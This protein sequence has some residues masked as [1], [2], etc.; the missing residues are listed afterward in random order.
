MIVGGLSFTKWRGRNFVGFVEFPS[1]R[2]T[3]MKK[4]KF[5]SST[6]VICFCL[7][8]RVSVRVSVT[9]KKCHNFW[10]VGRTG[11]KFSGP[12]FLL[13]SNFWAGEPD[14]AALGVRP[15]PQI[16]RFLPNLFPPGVL[17][18]GGRVA[19]FRNPDNEANKMLGAEFWVLPYGRR[20]RGQKAGL[21]RGADQN[22][23]I[24][25]FFIKGT[26]LKSG[27]GHFL[28]YATFW[29][30]APRGVPGGVKIKSQNW[31]IPHKIKF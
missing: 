21:A 14:S 3:Y 4:K 26:P 5:C 18:Q 22:F 2:L 16:N 15:G 9:L 29:S 28:F 6:E 17:G 23:G 31:R 8:V 12:S 19:P 27:A 10:T 20:K 13:T 30:D 11:A 7:S 24:S 25:I 1:F